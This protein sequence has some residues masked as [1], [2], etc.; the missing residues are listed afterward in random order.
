MGFLSGAYGKI[1]AG[2]YL[3]T[4]QH[5]ETML[6]ARVRH[7]TKQS[8]QFEKMLTSQ[9]RVMTDQLR[10]GSIAALQQY[11]V[12]NGLMDNMGNYIGG[13]SQEKLSAFTQQQMLSQ[14]NMTMQISQLESYFEMQREMYL[15]PLKDEED[16]IQTELDSLK[17]QIQLAKEEYDAKKEEEKAGAKNIAPDYT[18]QGS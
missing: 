12:T 5:K 16:A 6:Q 18:G 11:A 17:S 14:N 13:A 1:M 10:Q 2:K 8:A 7:V 9:K 4:L 15:E 3:R